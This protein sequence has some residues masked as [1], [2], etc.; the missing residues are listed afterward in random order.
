MPCSGAPAVFRTTGDSTTGDDDDDDDDGGSGTING[1]H[2]EAGA[3]TPEYRTKWA[4]GGGHAIERVGHGAISSAEVL[5]HYMK[6][7]S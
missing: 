7:A 4:L 6:L 5:F 3:N 2:L 1:L